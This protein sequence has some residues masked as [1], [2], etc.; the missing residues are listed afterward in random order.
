MPSE[1][2][3]TT[4]NLLQSC[5]PLLSLVAYLP[6]WK[7]LITTK[8]SA[9]ISLQS[10]LIWTASSVFAVFYAMVQFQVTG[11]GAALVFSSLSGLVFIIITVYLV[12]IYRAESRDYS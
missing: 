3:V 9:D 1:F 8:S 6:Q 5:V 2:V 4:A 7:K 12:Q 10:W 11:S